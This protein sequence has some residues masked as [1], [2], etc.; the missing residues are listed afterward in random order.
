MADTNTP[1]SVAS[2]LDS[3]LVLTVAVTMAGVL[4]GL[5][6][7]K[8]PNEN[9]PIIASIASALMGLVIGGYAGFRWGASESSKRPTPPTATSEPTDPSA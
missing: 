1:H 2:T 8:V 6:F 5:F 3:I 7:F 4:A 9:L